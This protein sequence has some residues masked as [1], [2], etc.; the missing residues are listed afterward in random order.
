MD[1]K[2]QRVLLICN[3]PQKSDAFLSVIQKLFL[4]YQHLPGS[5]DGLPAFPAQ[6]VFFFCLF[7][8]AS[9]WSG[10]DAFFSSVC[11]SEQ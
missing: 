8:V 6:A 4:F 1:V 10:Q 9:M 7:F 3:S 5:D 11:Y 2:E